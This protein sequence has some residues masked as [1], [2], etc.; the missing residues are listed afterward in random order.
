MDKWI[1]AGVMA[2]TH[3]TTA[4]TTTAAIGR[5]SAIQAPP[6]RKSDGSTMGMHDEPI[7][8]EVGSFSM[9]TAMAV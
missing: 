3:L 5:F 8:D 2:V 4:P 7:H 1:T 6:L 9:M